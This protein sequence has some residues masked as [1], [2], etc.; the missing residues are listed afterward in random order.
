[1]AAN[2]S[3]E[4]GLGQSVPTV[5]FQTSMQSVSVVGQKLKF[6]SCAALTEP[7]ETVWHAGSSPH[8][9]SLV[10][11]CPKAQLFAFTERTLE[12]K[13]NIFTYPSMM[14]KMVLE[15]PFDAVKPLEYTALAF[16][17]SGEQLAALC[18]L[19]E[20]TLVV[21]SLKTGSILAQ[22]PLLVP[23]SGL[24]FDP[25]SEGALCSMAPKRLLVWSL[26]LVYKTYLLESTEVRRP[27][28]RPIFFLLLAPPRV[29]HHCQS[30]TSLS[31]SH[32]PPLCAC[33]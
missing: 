28:A 6:A 23:T 3:A 24:S 26:K 13:I 14:P 15:L 32:L 33:V 12:A 1:M 29:T 20:P 27:P 4:A 30:L 16:S 22:G 25:P 21:W 11:T 5:A 9:I 7:D 18:G 17:R 19:P 31:P 2:L 8:G 10:A